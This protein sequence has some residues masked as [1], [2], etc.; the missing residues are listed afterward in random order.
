MVL[1]EVKKGGFVDPAWAE[2]PV[3]FLPTRLLFI[4][5]GWNLLR[6]FT[7]RL[8]RVDFA[9]KIYRSS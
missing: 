3:A 6:Q 4:L 5:S 9:V 8:E 2:D 1:S 7:V